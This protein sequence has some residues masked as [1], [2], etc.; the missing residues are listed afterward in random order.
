MLVVGREQPVGLE[1]VFTLSRNERTDGFTMSVVVC[2]ARKWNRV[3]KG[4]VYVSVC[5]S[6]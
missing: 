4:L 6:V 1:F 5:V 2:R 3:K